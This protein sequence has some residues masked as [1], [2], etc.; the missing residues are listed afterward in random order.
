[1]NNLKISHLLILCFL[2]V[3]GIEAQAQYIRGALISGVNLTQVDGDE[4]FGYHKAGLQIGASAIIQFNNKWGVSIENI[5]NQKGANQSA[6][7][8]EQP[9]GSY[10]LHLNYVEVPLLLQ[11]TDRD[12]I[13]VGAGLSWGNLVKVSEINKRD[14]ATLMDGTYKKYDWSLLGDLRFRLYKNFKLNL[15][16]AYSLVP[17]ASRNIKDSKTG[18]YNIRDQYNNVM[19]LR[20]IYIFNEPPRLNTERR[21]PSQSE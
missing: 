16:Y 10:H 11:Y 9:D 13:T 4:V 3:I 18:K 17:I 7:Y 21:P 8:S 14:T 1:M 12:R 20:L 5:F 19:S 15:R 2:V 6:L